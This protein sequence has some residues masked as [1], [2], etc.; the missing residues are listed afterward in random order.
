MA[1]VVFGEGLRG[2][3]LQAAG[4]GEAVFAQVV[5][6]V[7]GYV[8]DRAAHEGYGLGVLVV[9]GFGA[10]G[11]GEGEGDAV[12]GMPDS[13]ERGKGSGLGFGGDGLAVD[14]DGGGLGEPGGDAEVDGDQGEVFTDD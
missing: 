13:G 3:G 8:L 12:A 2:E 5:G 1:C 9:D 4:Q 10:E 11:L 7:E 14:G 6:W